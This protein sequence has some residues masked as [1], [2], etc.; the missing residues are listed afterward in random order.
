MSGTLKMTAMTS[1][2]IA[3]WVQAVGSIGA[4]LSA[5]WI[6]GGERRHRV[7]VENAARRDAFNRAI[8]ASEFAKKIVQNTVDFFDSSYIDRSQLPRFI[9]FIDQASA[10]VKE[11]SSGPGVDSQLQGHMFEVSNAMVDTKGLVEQYR[12]SILSNALM[13]RSF[14]SGNVKRIEKALKGLRDN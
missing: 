3:S 1:A 11:V 9:A 14:L 12:D 5:I 13:Q 10:R 4:I 7:Q 2:E 6:S 8:D